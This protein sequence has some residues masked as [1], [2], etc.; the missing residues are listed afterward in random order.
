MSTVAQVFAILGGIIGLIVIL[1]LIGMITIGA[2]VMKRLRDKALQIEKEDRRKDD[3]G[4]SDFVNNKKRG[5]C[6]DK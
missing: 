5:C 3:D 1:L 6:R 2:K 4:I